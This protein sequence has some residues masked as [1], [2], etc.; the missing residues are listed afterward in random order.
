MK[1]RSLIIA[2]LFLTAFCGIA[3]HASSHHGPITATSITAAASLELTAKDL[4]G[5]EISAPERYSAK[6]LYGYINGGAEIYLE[7]GFRQVTGQRCAQKKHELQVD[8]YEMVN[9]EAA[10]GMF[11]V[12]RG[13]CGAALPGTQW[14]CVTPEQILFAKGAYLVSIVPYDRA[15]E[16]RTA[17]MQAAKALVSR[18]RGAEFRTPPAFRSA[19]LSTSQKNLRYIHGPLALQSVLDEWSQWFDGVERFEMYHTVVGDGGR[20]TEAAT[21][22]F[23]SKRDAERFLSQCGA[24]AGKGKDGWRVDA[25]RNFALRDKGGQSMDVLY[26]PQME[27][28]RRSWK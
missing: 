26:G 16:T 14:H 23:R 2:I 21:V 5:W 8:I 12:L 27:S 17:A 7:Y 19:P 28:L 10:F 18:I 6:E 13:R 20:R 9:P 24:P 22:K 11:S 15:A 3:V 4:P 25:Q 1:P